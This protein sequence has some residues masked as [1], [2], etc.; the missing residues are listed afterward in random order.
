MRVLMVE[1]PCVK[2]RKVVVDLK[3]TSAR[4]DRCFPPD[5]LDDCL[6]RETS[7][8]GFVRIA[9]ELL[10]QFPNVRVACVVLIEPI[11]ESRCKR[12]CALFCHVVVFFLLNASRSPRLIRNV[13]GV[14]RTT[15]N[16]FALMYRLTV[17]GLTSR[18][19]AASLIVIRQTGGIHPRQIFSG[20]GGIHPRQKKPI[21]FG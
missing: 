5:A 16:N 4:L 1:L 3:L 12:H 10:E 13:R 19:I 15:G 21:R 9:S 2:R 8:T 7:V 6:S 18:N 14:N 17:H 11:R 20:S